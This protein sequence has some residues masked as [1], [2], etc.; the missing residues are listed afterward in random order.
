MTDLFAQY[1][2]VMMLAIVGELTLCF[3]LG[4]LVFKILHWIG[5]A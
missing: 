1:P 2:L 4:Y 3:A 5:R